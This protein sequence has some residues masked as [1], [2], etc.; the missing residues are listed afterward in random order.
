[1]GGLASLIAT[2][3]VD[4]GEKSD[5]ATVKAAAAHLPYVSDPAAFWA[6]CD[7]NSELFLLW[8]R[9]Y[10][11]AMERSL[12]SALATLR[13]PGADSFRIPYWN[14]LDHGSLPHEFQSSADPKLRSLYHKERFDE[15]DR[16]GD[17]WVRGD[18]DAAHGETNPYVRSDLESDP[19]KAFATFSRELLN[20][21]HDS[22]HAS[23]GKDMATSMTAARDPVFWV[24][25]A[26]IDRLFVAW[27]TCTSPGCKTHTIPDSVADAWNKAGFQFPVRTGPGI[28]EWYRPSYAELGLDE[29]MKNGSAEYD[30]LKRPEIL[31]LPTL[32]AAPELLQAQV[33]PPFIGKPG[34]IV[35]V[36]AANFTIKRAG[37]S[38]GLSRLSSAERRRLRKLAAQFLNAPDKYEIEVVIEGVERS[39]LSVTDQGTAS[40]RV[41]VF[42]DL[43]KTRTVK[44][45]PAQFYRQHY[46]GTVNFFDAK[47]GADGAQ[48]FKIDKSVKDRAVK[49]LKGRSIF[50]P[51]VNLVISVIPAFARNSP[52]ATPADPVL[53]ISRAAVVARRVDG[54]DTM[55]ASIH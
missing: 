22:L 37:I 40:A 42:V 55:S 20:G 44:L 9:A 7:H 50:S 11:L 33:Q 1:M 23:V 32:H 31:P 12:R 35:L 54:T 25:H 3:G 34:E 53:K 13:K 18:G 29:S 43:D 51:P 10:V 16:Q 41:R 19:S 47:P 24:H 30:D 4:L 38:F 5:E 39:P 21:W 6:K 8:H 2:H 45:T 27:L 28:F 48:R 46:L 49:A 14:W 17:I 15:A 36:S 52:T 26:N